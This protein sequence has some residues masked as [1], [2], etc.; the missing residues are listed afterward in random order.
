MRGNGWR[1]LTLFDL[2]SFCYLSFEG[3]NC[4]DFKTIL[5]LQMFPDPFPDPRKQNTI[6][7]QAQIQRWGLFQYKHFLVRPSPWKCMVNF[8]IYSEWERQHFQL[9]RHSRL[10]SRAPGLDSLGHHGSLLMSSQIL[11]CSSGLYGRIMSSMY[12]CYTQNTWH[13]FGF[14]CLVWSH[15]HSLSLFHVPL[16]VYLRVGLGCGTK[17]PF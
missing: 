9:K 14:Q 17:Q 15:I 16:F 7:Q 1:R 2:K 6:Q 5:Q 10:Q 12:T 11:I 8:S 3:E 4:A 13:Y